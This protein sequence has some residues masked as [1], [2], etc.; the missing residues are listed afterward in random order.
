MEGTGY[1]TL[2]QNGEYGNYSVAVSELT[3][4]A[5]PADTE[6]KWLK[7]P[8][9]TMI[10][11]A[12]MVG[13]DLGAS[14]QLGYRYLDDAAGTSVADGLIEAGASEGVREYEGLPI[15]FDEAIAITSLIT[16]GAATGRAAVIVEYIYCG[17]P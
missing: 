7:L 1:K 5:T 10:I 2:Q 6:V 16:G 11:G 3:A 12:R 15:K 9:G 17:T 14:L 8:P 4:D 13:E